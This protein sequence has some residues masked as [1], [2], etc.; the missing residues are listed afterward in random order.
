MTVDTCLDVRNDPGEEDNG[1]V[2]TGIVPVYLSVVS[3]SCVFNSSNCSIYRNNQHMRCSYHYLCDWVRNSV[4]SMEHCAVGLDWRTGLHDVIRRRHLLF[5]SPALQCLQNTRFHPRGKEQVL[6]R[7]RQTHFRDKPDLGL[8][9]SPVRQPLRDRRC[10][11]DHHVHQFEVR[12][13]SNPASLIC[14]VLSAD[15][16]FICFV[17]GLFQGD[18]ESKL[19]S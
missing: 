10:L 8:W 1:V 17:F 15:F 18:P 9:S 13:S 11:H 7:R 3:R 6:H 16:S 14:S 2:R 4:A 19:L 5:C 12:P